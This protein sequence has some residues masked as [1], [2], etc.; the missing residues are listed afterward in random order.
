MR[1]PFTHKKLEEVKDSAADFG[2]GE[3]MEARFAQADVEAEETGCL[4][5]IVF[6]PHHDGDGEIVPGWWSD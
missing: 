5:A 1:N 4:E 3:A 6:G 2:H